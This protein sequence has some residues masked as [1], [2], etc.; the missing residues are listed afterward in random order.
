MIHKRGLRTWTL[1]KCSVSWTVNCPQSNGLCGQGY[2]IYGILLKYVIKAI[3]Y[4]ASSK[5]STVASKAQRDA[6]GSGNNPVWTPCAE[7]YLLNETSS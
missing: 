6:N 1:G 3:D 5:V 7:Q 2:N 4:V